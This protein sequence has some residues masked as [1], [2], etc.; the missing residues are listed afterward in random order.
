MVAENNKKPVILVLLIVQIAI[1]FFILEQP[2]L[3]NLLSTTELIRTALNGPVPTITL[4]QKGI[5]LEGELPV[6]IQLRDNIWL[7]FDTFADSS[8]FLAYAPRS[9]WLSNDKLLFRTKKGIASF[10]LNKV[11][12]SDSPKTY[13]G[14]EIHDKFEK[15]YRPGKTLI[16]V[17]SIFITSVL[18]FFLVL[19]GGGVGLIIDAFKDGPSTYGQMVL[20]SAQLLTVWVIIAAGVQFAGLFSQHVLGVVFV[21]YLISIVL[22]VNYSLN[23]KL[24]VTRSS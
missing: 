12:S 5:S 9:T 13:S 10:D 8:E 23:H 20:L 21:L 22:V 17:L 16:F 2:V 11:S 15:Y 24:N 3:R 1:V 18:L 19:L 14:K 4:L 7:I 6:R